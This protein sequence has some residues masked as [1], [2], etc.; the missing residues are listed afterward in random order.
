L[1]CPLAINRLK[2]GVPATVEHGVDNKGNKE[3]G[4]YI[5]K[6]VQVS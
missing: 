2:V 1:N 5:A 6:T 3:D 4:K